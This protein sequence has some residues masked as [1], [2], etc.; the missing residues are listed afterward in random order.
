MM[1]DAAGIEVR[2]SNPGKVFFPDRDHPDELWV[3]LDPTPEASWDG[4]RCIALVIGEVL[5]DHVSP[6]FRKQSG[7]PKRVQPSRERKQ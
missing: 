6:H 3:D 1:I 7:E 5:A 2:F 4:V